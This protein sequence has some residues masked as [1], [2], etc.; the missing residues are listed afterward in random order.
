METDEK[1][2]KERV[3][4][5]PPGPTNVIVAANI[6]RARAAI[7]LDL[8]EMAVR[9]TAAGRVISHT[10]LSKVENLERRVDVDDLT[11]IAYVLGTT[12]ADLLIPIEGFE[13]PAPDQGETL[14][15]PLIPGGTAPTPTG[16]PEGK[17]LDEEIRA[18]IRGIDPL[19]VAGLVWYWGNQFEATKRHIHIDKDLLETYARRGRGITTVTD[20]EKRIAQYEERLVFIQNR[21]IDLDPSQA[22]RFT[23]DDAIRD[24]IT[25][26]RSD[27]SSPSPK[28]NRSK[29]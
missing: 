28:T 27:T 2:G 3:R 14:L 17:Y 20:Y 16:V 6:R 15:E 18:W 22:E 1:P 8:R 9:M 13:D 24:A 21:I 25:R 11:A 12:P 23:H 29:P 4:G 5:N 7:G 19:T 26:G 10:G